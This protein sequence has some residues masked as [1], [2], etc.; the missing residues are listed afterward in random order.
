MKCNRKS[1]RKR[2]SIFLLPAFMQREYIQAAKNEYEW[3][4]SPMP[5]KKQ[6]SYSNIRRTPP[7]SSEDKAILDTC[8]E[9]NQISSK[10][11]HCLTDRQQAHKVV[12]KI[13]TPSHVTSLSLARPEETPSTLVGY[14]RERVGEAPGVSR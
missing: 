10:V 2:G 13:E 11:L 1:P 5:S 3:D 14:H 6:P 12:I 8:R 7:V 4:F 9:E